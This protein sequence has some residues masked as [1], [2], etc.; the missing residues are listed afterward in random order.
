MWNENNEHDNKTR[1]KWHGISCQSIHAPRVRS[2]WSLFIV[3][4][5]QFYYNAL[6][7]PNHLPGNRVYGKEGNLDY[8]IRSPLLVDQWRAA[9][10]HVGRGTSS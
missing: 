1:S 8:Y 3:G 10:C 7:A 5:Q 2:P 9:T 6:K 4:V